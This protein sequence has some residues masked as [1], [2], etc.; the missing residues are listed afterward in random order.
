M[1]DEAKYTVY[2]VPQEVLVR[3]DIETLYHHSGDEALYSY[4]DHY[5][6]GYDWVQVASWDN[7]QS[8]GAHSYKETIT[9]SLT[10]KRGSEWGVEWGIK[11]AFKGL[12]V[13]VGGSYKQFSEEETTNSTSHEI[14]ANVPPRSRL[15]LYQKRY[16]FKTNLWFVLDAWGSEHTVGNW[17][18]PGVAQKQGFIDIDSREYITTSNKLDSDNEGVC[19]V[20]KAATGVREPSN[21]LQFQKCTSRCQKLLHGRGI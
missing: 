20:S 4:M 21:V 12:E 6:L 11:G 3:Q 19:T 5:F 15:Y 2:R 7:T 16:R 1:S 13:S 18:G 9:S 8:S 17:E 14:T 10:V